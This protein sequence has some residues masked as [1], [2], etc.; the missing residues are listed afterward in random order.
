[1]KPDKDHIKDIF[2]S[3]LKGFEPDLPPSLW[4]KIEA[5]LPVAPVVRKSPARIFRHTI[6]TWTAVAAAV[7]LLALLFVPQEH[8]SGSIA[9]LPDT[10][11]TKTNA[12]VEQPKVANSDKSGVSDNVVESAQKHSS[13]SLLAESKTTKTEVASVKETFPEKTMPEKE[14]V[15]IA[16]VNKSSE[17]VD[18]NT[19][20]AEEK[21]T[22]NFEP[23]DADFDRDLKAR[24]AAFEAEGEKT[25]NILA[26]NNIPVKTKKSESEPK[27]IALGIGGGSGLSRSDEMTNSLRY[28]NA[29]SD[30]PLSLSMQKKEKLKMEHNQPISFGIAVN[31]KIT[32]RISIES[33]IVYTYISARIKEDPNMEFK[34]NDLQYF[35]Y[36]G[37]PLSV[38]YKLGEWKKVEFYASAGG[39]IQKDIYGRLNS[40]SSIDGLINFEK[41]SKRKISQERPQFSV[42]GLLG[43]SY[44]LYNKLAAYT[45]FGG[46]YYFDAGNQYQ[47]IF[48]DK[49]W[50]FNL[51]L[52]LK[53]GF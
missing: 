39:M 33:G 27:G 9:G 10:N 34:Q 32:N 13:Y 25:R 23:K 1:M 38:N 46:A 28:A 21:S 49:K 52:G 19:Y 20:V 26:D 29:S 42:M 5:D 30:G 48:S 6:F 36:L 8:D 3:K 40:D 2:S 11:T 44:P 16:P 12:P 22:E 18:N 15:T 17:V 24:I 4:E 45:S 53:F 37:I 41:S 51:N 35:H 7:V 43:I 14:T 50:L 47:T 31:K